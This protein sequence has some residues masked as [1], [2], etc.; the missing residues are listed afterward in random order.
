MPL[1]GMTLLLQGMTLHPEESTPRALQPVHQPLGSLHP[2]PARPAPAA[3]RGTAP[4]TARTAQRS[5]GARPC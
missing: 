3:G 1:Q 5:G 2:E 4:S